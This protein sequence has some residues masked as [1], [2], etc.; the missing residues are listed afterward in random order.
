[1]LLPLR[2][3]KS[4]DLSSTNIVK[5]PALESLSRFEHYNLSDNYIIDWNIEETNFNNL[6]SLKTLDLSNNYIRIINGT[7]FPRKIINSLQRLNLQGNRFKCTCDLLWFTNWIKNYN[8]IIINY[9]KSN[10]TYKLSMEIYM[11]PT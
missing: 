11:Q 7:S 1:M 9:Y 4:L 3:L 8:Y 5:I 10:N 2:K 6:K